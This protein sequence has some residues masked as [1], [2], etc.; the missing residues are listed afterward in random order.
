MVDVSGYFEISVFEIKRED[1]IGIYWKSTLHHMWTGQTQIY[2][3]IPA[4][5]PTFYF[6]MI[7]LTVKTPDIWTIPYLSRQCRSRQAAP[8]ILIRICSLFIYPTVLY[9]FFWWGMLTFLNSNIG[10]YFKMNGN[11][12]R[13]INY[14]ILAHLYKSTGSYCCH[15]GP[16][17]SKLTMS[18]V[19]DSLKFQ[20]LISQ[21]CQYFLSKKCE[22]LLQRKSVSHFFNKKYQCIWSWS[23]KTLYELTS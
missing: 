23:R 16:G 10:K 1:L 12:F 3:L 19:N 6:P 17:C 15:S 21:I 18:I 14:I 7:C 22:K 2:L 9:K 4:S 5:L 13:G 11:I 20:T 8:S